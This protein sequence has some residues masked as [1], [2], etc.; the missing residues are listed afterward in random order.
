M[1]LVGVPKGWRQPFPSY[2]SEKHKD[3][4]TK[5]ADGSV[6]IYIGP[7]APEGKEANWLQ[8]VP[9]KGWF[10]LLRVYSPTEAW[11]EGKWLPGEF[12]LME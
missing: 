9:G 3:V 11:F 6:D 4:Y 5:N 8:T 12:E 1:E 10:T 2:N 7:N